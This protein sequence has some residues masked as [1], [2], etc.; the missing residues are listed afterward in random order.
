M[1]IVSMSTAHA[2]PTTQPTVIPI[3][4]QSALKSVPNERAPRTPG[5]KFKNSCKNDLAVMLHAAGFR[6]DSLRMAWAIVMRES[7]GQ[8]LDESS[9]YYTGAL[10]IWQ[11]QTSA[12]S[13]QSWWSRSAMLD[14][15]RQSRIAYKYLSKKGTDWRHWGLSSGGQLDTTYYSNWSSW[16]WENWIMAPFR[17]YYAQ[18]PC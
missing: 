18:Y 17:K 5:Q 14:P 15:K 4:A 8:N 16:Q 1:S 13:G 3:E 7:K 12:W 9:P 2:Q 11:I 6:N 10:G